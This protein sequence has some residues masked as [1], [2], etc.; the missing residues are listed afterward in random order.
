M[1]NNSDKIIAKCY[2]V[3]GTHRYYRTESGETYSITNGKH[4]FYCGNVYKKDQSIEY[5]TGRRLEEV[6]ET[7]M[8]VE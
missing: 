6:K 8:F 3:W 5:L 1:T 7:V 4:F 2:G